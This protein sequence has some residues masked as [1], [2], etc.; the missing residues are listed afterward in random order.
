MR[1]VYLD[2]LC[3]SVI[4]V[5]FRLVVA[6]IYTGMAGSKRGRVVLMLLELLFDA[7][8]MKRNLEAKSRGQTLP[9]PTMS[10]QNKK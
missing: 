5:F 8:F 9:R 1:A 7:R 4:R 2:K 6:H 3:K 10:F